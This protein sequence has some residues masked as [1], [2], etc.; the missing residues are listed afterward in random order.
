MT[1]RGPVLYRSVSALLLLLSSAGLAAQSAPLR[2]GTAW[3][4]EQWPEQ[5]WEADLELMQAAHMNVVRV[6]EFAWS[7]MEPSED[8]FDFA[9]LD[10]AIAMAAKH[11]IAV[12]M[13]TPTAAPPAWLTVQGCPPWRP[14]AH[15]RCPV[16]RRTCT[17]LRRR[18]ARQQSRATSP[19]T[20]TS[21][22]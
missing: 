20:T 13:G 12:V 10:K 22:R 2:F 18:P 11:H 9:W 3:Y 6:G 8:H 19:G 1:M 7:M 17:R 21:A 5:R 16:R 14:R 15:D 4:P